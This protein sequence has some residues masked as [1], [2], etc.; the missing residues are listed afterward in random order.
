MNDTVA[1]SAYDVENAAF[2]LL[3][4]LKTLAEQ[5]I[6]VGEEDF[7]RINTAIDKIATAHELLAEA[8]ALL[9]DETKP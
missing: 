9:R 7:T 3:E 6:Q 2:I 4:L 5:A 1:G 8:R